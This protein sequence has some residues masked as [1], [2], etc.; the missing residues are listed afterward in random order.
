MDEKEVERD[1]VKSESHAGGWV[2][3][4]ERKVGYREI[5]RYGKGGVKKRM[6]RKSQKRKKSEKR[7]RQNDKYRHTINTAQTA[8]LILNFQILLK[9][10]TFTGSI[11]LSAVGA[12]L[13]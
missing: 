6:T 13:E 9:C 4:E 11:F 5:I 3:E 7:G 8:T 2:G 12:A 1:E 10:K